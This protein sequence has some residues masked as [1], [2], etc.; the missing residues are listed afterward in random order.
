M[1]AGL[2]VGDI[3]GTSVTPRTDLCGG[4]GGLI[5]ANYGAD[6]SYTKLRIV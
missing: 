3:G 5:T 4:V 1:L 6:A 2:L